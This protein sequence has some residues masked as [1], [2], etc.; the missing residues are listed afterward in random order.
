[1][2]ASSIFPTWCIVHLRILIKVTPFYHPNS[3]WLMILGPAKMYHA[4]MLYHS[5]SEISHC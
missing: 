5:D 1:M 2:C 4:D 3:V